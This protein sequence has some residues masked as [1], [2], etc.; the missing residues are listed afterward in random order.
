[1][2]SNLEFEDSDTLSTFI[3][4]IQ[5]IR[6]LQ[7][8]S[9]IEVENDLEVIWSQRMYLNFLKQIHLEYNLNINKTYKHTKNPIAGEKIIFNGPLGMNLIINI[10]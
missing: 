1:M 6:Y 3:D 4:K 9:E 7:L 8:E 2:I 5:D 10:T